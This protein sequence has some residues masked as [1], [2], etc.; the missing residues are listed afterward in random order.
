MSQILSER[1]LFSFFPLNVFAVC[2]VDFVEFPVSLDGKA[3]VGIIC[4]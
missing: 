1:N 2:K 3:G 4:L